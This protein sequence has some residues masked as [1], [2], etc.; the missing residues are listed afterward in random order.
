MDTVYKLTRPD[1]T[2]YKGFLWKP[3]EQYHFSGLGYLCSP[4]FAHAYLTPELAVLL[5]PIHANYNPAILWRAEGMIAKRDHD[6]KV[7]CTDLILCAQIP[8]PEASTSQRVEFAVRCALA[9]YTEPTF[10]L[11]A[12]NW[13]VGID[14]T[15]ESAEKSVRAAEAAEAAAWAARAGILNLPDLARTVLA[16]VE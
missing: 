3:N 10:V 8:L 14:K 4:G 9:V 16:K 2:T 1:G 6:L 15:E 13:L 11:W 5:N 12:N 7:G